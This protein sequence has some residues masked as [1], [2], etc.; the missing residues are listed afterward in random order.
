MRKIVC[1]IAIV[2]PVVCGADISHM[3]KTHFIAG[4]ADSDQIRSVEPPISQTSASSVVVPFN[5]ISGD[6]IKAVFF[7]PDDRVHEVLSYLIS[8]EKQ[9]IR[10]AMFAFTDKMIAQNLIAAKRRGV[11]VELITDASSVYGKYNKCSLLADGNIILYV[12]NPQRAEQPLQG[13]M[14]NKFFLFQDNILGRSIVWTGSFNA[15]GAACK[16]NRENVVVS[17]ERVY[18][19]KFLQEFERLKMCCDHYQQPQAVLREQVLP[20]KQMRTSKK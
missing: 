14:H 11:R 16:A 17:E 2:M 1:G 20:A 6:Q 10:V 12:Y 5:L 15:T 3:G 8:Q 7:S 18:A 4:C 13:V 9:H 19:E